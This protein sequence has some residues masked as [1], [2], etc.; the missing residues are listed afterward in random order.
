MN[1]KIFFIY[2][3][4]IMIVKKLTELVVEILNRVKRISLFDKTL[5]LMQ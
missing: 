5:Y 1:T 2:T 4:A 3:D